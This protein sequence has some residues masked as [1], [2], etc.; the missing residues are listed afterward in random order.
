MTP[1]KTTIHS[2]DTD[3][4]REATADRQLQDSSQSRLEAR[5]EDRESGPGFVECFN[6]SSA[7]LQSSLLRHSNADYT[8][9][10]VTVQTHL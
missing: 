10:N 4:S 2:N 6:V 3:S 9:E 8:L 5:G 1:T 7:F